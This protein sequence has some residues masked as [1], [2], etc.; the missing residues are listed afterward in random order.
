MIMIGINCGIHPNRQLER[1][2]YQHHSCRRKLRSRPDMEQR[3]LR[4]CLWRTSRC[5]IPIRW[6]ISAHALCQSAKGWEY[7]P[8]RHSTCRQCQRRSVTRNVK[9]LLIMN[10]PSL[11]YNILHPCM[12]NNTHLYYELSMKDRILFLNWNIRLRS[13]WQTSEM[14]WKLSSI[15]ILRVFEKTLV[16]SGRPV[17]VKRFGTFRSKEANKATQSPL[18]GTFYTITHE[19]LTFFAHWAIQK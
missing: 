5:K 6:R 7:Q 16:E 18:Y 14:V 2:Q 8:L 9:Y 3:W 12:S 15:L 19:S 11:I 1:W 10:P 13:N 17:S 4:E